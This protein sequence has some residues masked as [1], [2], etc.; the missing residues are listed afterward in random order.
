M[1]TT[2]TTQDDAARRDHEAIVGRALGALFA[3][4]KAKDFEAFGF[5]CA[6]GLNPVTDAEDLSDEITFFFMHVADKFRFSADDIARVADVLG[7]S[8]QWLATGKPDTDVIPEAVDEGDRQV[9]EDIALVCRQAS[10]ADG[11]GCFW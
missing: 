9:L 1:D 4:G 5:A 10:R 8:F 3:S 7:V 2:V 6:L 11:D